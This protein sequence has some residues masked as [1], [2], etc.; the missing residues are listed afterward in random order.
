LSSFVVSWL[1][2]TIGF[3]IGHYDTLSRNWADPVDNAGIRF[4]YLRLPFQCEGQCSH[5]SFPASLLVAICFHQV[6]EGLSL[7]I[8]IDGLPP[9]SALFLCT[10]DNT[11]APP[12]ESTRLHRPSE[13][14]TSIQL[15]QEPHLKTNWLKTVLSILFAITTPFG[16][17]VGLYAFPQGG[18]G[19]GEPKQRGTLRSSLPWTLALLMIARART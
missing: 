9:A 15:H 4:W 14:Y 13:S 12:S 3:T 8:R 17:I 16:M 11:P 5:L 6:F 7:G 10:Q 18:R 1:M 2:I 19:D